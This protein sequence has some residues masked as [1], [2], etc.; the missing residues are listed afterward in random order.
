METRASLT[1]PHSRAPLRNSFPS[2]QGS[3][4][5]GKMFERCLRRTPDPSFPQVLPSVFLLTSDSTE[6]PPLRWLGPLRHG[7]SNI[8]SSRLLILHHCFL[9]LGGFPRTRRRSTSSLIFFFVEM[10]IFFMCMGRTFS[11]Y[12]FFALY[13]KSPLLFLF[14]LSRFPLDRLSRNSP[15]SEKRVHVLLLDFHPIPTPPQETPLLIET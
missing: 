7:R 13:D 4:I 10:V 3:S 1:N 8:S 2:W 9:G 15:T 6:Y 5:Q 11:H 14:N 12:L